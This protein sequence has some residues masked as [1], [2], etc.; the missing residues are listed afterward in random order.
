[1]NERYLA[2]DITVSNDTWKTGLNN[3]DI[4]IGPSGSGKTT[5]YVIP[6]INQHCDSMVVAD[7]KGDLYKK[8]SPSLQADGYE[9]YILDFINQENSCAYN[10]L[11]YI[12]RG[13]WDLSYSQQDLMSL[14]G[15]LIPLRTRHDPFWEESARTVLAS[16]IGFV[17]EALPKEE[18]HLGSVLE[19]FRVIGTEKGR[20]IFDGWAM[21][22]PE[23]FAVKKYKM[24][25]QLLGVEKTW[26]CV[27]QFLAEALD[28][29]DYDGAQVIFSKPPKFRI[30][31]LG[32]RK[33]ALFVNIS[34]T[35]RAFDRL[36]N[37][38]YTQTLQCL[39]REAEKNKDNRL[40]VPV[41][42]ILDDFATNVFIPHFDKLISVIRSREISVSVILQSI[43]QLESL[44]TAAEAATIINNC[45]HMIYL[46]GQDL[47]TVQYIGTRANKTPH[48]VLKM[49]REKA[50]LFTRGEDARLVDKINPFLEESS[51][52]EE[53]SWEEEV[54]KLLFT[55]DWDELPF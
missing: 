26:G 50:Y 15:T 8:L 48:S 39:C 38:F 3:N 45:D 51:E 4:I 27:R 7:T 10:P 54:E 29:F 24:Y 31:E 33:I 17:L 1:M 20:E 12:R 6:N 9:V 40:K 23:S 49:E 13:A 46:G 47:Q 22:Y 19:L 35:D 41:R 53:L 43:T 42:I 21:E 55:D 52:D 2:K 11:D 14:A 16:L 25:E 44:Y 37:T 36:V 34:D 5:G 30:E 32:R 18:Q 28:V